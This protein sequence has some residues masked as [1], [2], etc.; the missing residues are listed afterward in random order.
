M[1]IGLISDTHGSLPALE[2]VLNACRAAACDVIVHAGDFL[3]SPFSPDPPGESVALLR[4]ESL[5]V[6]LGNNELYLRDWGTPHWEA[7][8]GQRRQRPDSPDFFLPFIPA[9]QAELSPADLAWLRSLPEELVLDGARAGDVYVC[10][11]MPGNSFVT[12]W[13]SDVRYT[14]PGF[15]FQ[16]QVAT[17][18]ARPGVADADLILCGHTHQPLIQ[19][20]NLPNGRSALVVRCSGGT[21]TGT[22]PRAWYCGYAIM[23]HRAPTAT[24]YLEWEITVG[25]VPY[26]P[27]DPTWRWDQPAR[28]SAAAP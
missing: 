13:D 6:I 26:L 5:P 9:G 18:L 16:E 27:R 15:Q 22:P 4:A 20:T 28:R 17:A 14:P 11:G 7:T 3:S 24:S 25:T 23:T 12:P 19:R 21:S 8:L 10:H 2:A 1:R